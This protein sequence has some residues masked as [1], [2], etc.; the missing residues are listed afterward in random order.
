M[1]SIVPGMGVSTLACACVVSC[2]PGVARNTVACVAVARS[3]YV[4]TAASHSIEFAITWVAY[5]AV[6]LCKDIAQQMQ[7]SKAS[8]TLSA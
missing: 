7:H 1:M 6:D 4:C 2:V 3:R 8:I 5:T